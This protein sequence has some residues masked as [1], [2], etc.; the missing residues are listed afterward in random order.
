MVEFRLRLYRPTALRYDEFIRAIELMDAED[1]AQANGS[2]NVNHAVHFI[3][4]R[5]HKLNSE[6]YDSAMDRASQ[7]FAMY[8]RTASIVFALSLC[9]F[10]RLDAFV[11]Y[12]TI[13]RNEDVRAQLALQVE[14]LREQV[15]AE[16][17]APDA[18]TEDRF[19]ELLVGSELNLDG[20]LN[21]LLDEIFARRAEGADGSGTTTSGQHPD[22]YHGCEE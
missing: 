8:M 3:R 22:F 16:A 14:V 1:P 17:N 13:E 9:F 21:T 19:N 18:L 5:D 7:H 15:D 2:W 10:W 11:I 20:P 6:R 12:E 4:T